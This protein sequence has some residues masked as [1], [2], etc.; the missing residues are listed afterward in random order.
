MSNPEQKKNVLVSRLT[1]VFGVPAHL[2]GEKAAAAFAAEI[3]RITA[4]FS[5]AALDRA[6][7]A[8]IAGGGKSWPTPKVIVDACAEAQEAIDGA[9]AHRP[10]EPRLW[11][12]HDKNA[13]AWA[14]NYCRVTEIGKRA[15]AEGWGRSVWNWA[16]SHARES[17]RYGASP[18][19]TCRPTT[20][21]IECWV[22]YCRVPP[23]W[24]ERERVTLLNE[25][26][27][28][29]TNARLNR[30]IASL[31]SGKPFA[32]PTFKQMPAGDDAA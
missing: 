3:R 20:G 16:R 28:P 1:D 5:D 2:E 17:Y 13:D 32:L 26:W 21:E 19:V 15:F 30:T 8:L 7:S 29:E 24:L 12:T 18:D 25:P 6:A 22:R 4:G 14:T 11:H 10:K 9:N 27:S 31:R 23:T